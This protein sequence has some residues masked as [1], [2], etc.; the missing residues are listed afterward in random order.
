[1]GT[2]TLPRRTMKGFIFPFEGMIADNSFHGSIVPNLSPKVKRSI[3][4]SIDLYGADGGG[5][6]H[7]SSRIPDFESG[8]SANSATS[9]THETKAF[10]SRRPFMFPI[11]PRRQRMA[12]DARFRKCGNRDKTLSAEITLGKPKLAAKRSGRAGGQFDPEAAPPGKMGT[13]QPWTGPP[14]EY[15]CWRPA[16]KPLNSGFLISFPA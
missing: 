12:R 10:S 14:E 9:A 3:K 7:T 2:P 11:A 13:G 4:I 1:M 8:A 5:R 16:G 15:L 6:T